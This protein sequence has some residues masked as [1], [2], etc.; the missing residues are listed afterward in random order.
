M[1]VKEEYGIVHGVHQE[2]THSKKHQRRNN[3]INDMLFDCTGTFAMLKP[4]DINMFSQIINK[5]GTIIVTGLKSASRQ[6]RLASN[7]ET[8]DVTP[9]NQ[10]IAALQGTASIFETHAFQE[11]A[12]TCFISM[13]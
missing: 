3:N 4:S 12:C 7:G 11:I 6:E 13:C 5:S 9:C 8:P 10:S 2:K 1:Q